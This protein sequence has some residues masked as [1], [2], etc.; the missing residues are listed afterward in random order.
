MELNACKLL[1]LSASINFVLEGFDEI[2]L[3][4]S[5]NLTLKD[6]FLLFLMSSN[7]SPNKLIK[8]LGIAKSNLALISSKLIKEGLVEKV[9]DE[10]DGRMIKFSLTESGREKAKEIVEKLNKNLASKLDFKNK[11]NE[12]NL[13]VDKLIDL[14]K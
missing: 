8:N 1:E 9:K 3:S 11:D 13:L 7:L 6:K 2:Y 5:C 4:K 12:I 10:L 14:L